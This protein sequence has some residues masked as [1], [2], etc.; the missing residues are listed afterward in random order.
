MVII[1]ILIKVKGV[2]MKKYFFYV[3]MIISV[4]LFC[5]GFINKESNN[6]SNNNL[7]ETLSYGID[8]IPKDLE[9]VTNLSKQT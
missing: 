4:I 9:K 6:L 1:L 7:E 5:L 3:V 2:I 8:E